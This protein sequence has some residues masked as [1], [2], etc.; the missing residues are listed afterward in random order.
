V[1]NHRHFYFAQIGH[2]HFAPTTVISTLILSKG[3]AT[4]FHRFGRKEMSPGSVLNDARAQVETS[5]P[6]RRLRPRYPI[7]LQLQYKLTNQDPGK[8]TGSGRTLSISSGGIF[9]QT[10][11]RLP[12]GCE[13]D[14]AIDW[15]CL[16]NGVSLLKLVAHGHVVRHDAKGTA[17]EVSRY[18]FRTRRAQPPR[19]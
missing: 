9:F 5:Q 4:I 17:V 13:I 18:E 16:L 1:H 12:V 6:D 11:N 19:T 14:L 2:Y 7:I 8:Q 15:P 3:N 10:T